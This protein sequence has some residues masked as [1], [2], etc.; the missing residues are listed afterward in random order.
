MRDG[1]GL[2]ATVHFPGADGPAAGARYPTI[3]E[4]T[5]SGKAVML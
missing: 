1:I 2:A 3:L 5:P 4:R